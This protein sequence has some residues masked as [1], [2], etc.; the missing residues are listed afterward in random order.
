MATEQIRFRT[1][2]R[3]S[4]VVSAPA[5]TL[6]AI[7]AAKDWKAAAMAAFDAAEVVREDYAGAGSTLRSCSAPLRPEWRQLRRLDV[8]AHVDEGYLPVAA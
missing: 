2:S 1:N 4:Y 8:R 5:G 7:E 3:T 6:A